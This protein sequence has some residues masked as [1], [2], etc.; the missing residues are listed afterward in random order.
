MKLYYQEELMLFKTNSLTELNVT[1]DSEKP[2][3]NTNKGYKISQRWSLFTL[4][5]FWVFLT[6]EVIGGWKATIFNF[7]SKNPD[8]CN[9]EAQH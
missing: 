4:A 5:G 9:K 2:F 7:L 1:L 8:H 6:T 3:T